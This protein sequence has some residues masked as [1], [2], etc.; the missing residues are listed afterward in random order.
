MEV[1]PV[2]PFSIWHI[3]LIAIVALLLFGPNKLPELGRGAGRMFKEF[4][5]ATSG[6]T[7]DETSTHT[8]KKT[9]AEE[10]V[11]SSSAGEV[12]ADQK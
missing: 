2:G 12:K 11:S 7:S 9:T 6:I 1:Q 3:L 10:N 5:D 8:E 4:K